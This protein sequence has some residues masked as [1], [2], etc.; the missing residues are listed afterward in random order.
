[1]LEIAAKLRCR[2][3]MIGFY[4]IAELRLSGSRRVLQAMSSGDRKR[5]NLIC[6]ETLTSGDRDLQDR[7]DRKKSEQ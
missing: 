1:M 7:R 4:K 3:R 5:E 6:P 2:H